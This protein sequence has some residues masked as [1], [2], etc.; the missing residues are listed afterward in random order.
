MIEPY[1]E[2][3]GITIYCGDC[4]D[5]LPTIAPEGVDLVLT[6]PPYGENTHSM[7][8][9]NRIGTTGKQGNRSLSGNSVPGRFAA[10]G[11]DDLRRVLEV[12]RNLTTS[13]IVSNMDY[14]H[15]FGFDATPPEG[16][17]MLRVGV[18]I[19]TN[20]MPMISADRPGQGWE[21]IAYLHRDD[22]KPRWNG[23]GRHGNFVLPVEQD[24]GHATAKPLA[25]IRT[26]VQRF[27]DPDDLILDPFMGS[28]TTLRAAKD[29]G[30][31]AIGIE[32]EERYCEIA[33][34]RLQQ[35]VLPLEVP[36]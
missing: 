2:Q 27:T 30:R 14:R 15:A 10:I 20:P 34:K 3:D 21:A 33:V 17:R 8:R 18:W 24:S 4:R 35:S 36:A 11:D 12:C 6:D 7:A 19:K 13:W 9:T 23:G 16:L 26:L 32:I 29:L 28:G 31:R 1:Y 22:V 5:V 25:M